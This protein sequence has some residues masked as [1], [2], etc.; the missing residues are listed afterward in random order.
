MILGDVIYLVWH[1]FEVYEGWS[2]RSIPQCLI[3]D[4]CVL[5]LS[6]MSELIWIRCF[7]SDLPRTQHD[8]LS[9]TDRSETQK[10]RH[11]HAIIYA[12]AVFLAGRTKTTSFH[13][14]SFK[15]VYTTAQATRDH[16]GR[17]FLRKIEAKA[18]ARLSCFFHFSPS[19]SFQNGLHGLYLEA[20]DI[21]P[22]GDILSFANISC[23]II[24]R[25][26]RVLEQESAKEDDFTTWTMNCAPLC[27]PTILTTTQ[28]LQ[29]S[30]QRFRGWSAKPSACHEKE[31]ILQTRVVSPALD[32][33]SA[34]RTVAM[35][36][37]WNLCKE[38]WILVIT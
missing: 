11:L 14:E 12:L 32:S 22:L 18:I 26:P 29:K 20:A 7:S 8:K 35:K 21:L 10:T 38:S 37:V 27:L 5:K 23:W 33:G 19:S 6:A 30:Q 25:H 24:Y 16:P 31:Y 34:T 3:Y 1:P 2:G 13:S 9:S 28:P 15:H 4:L 36:E 17:L